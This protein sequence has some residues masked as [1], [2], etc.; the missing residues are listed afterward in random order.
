[1]IHAVRTFDDG[2][3]LLSYIFI[4][5]HHGQNYV[6]TDLHIEGVK[7][8]ANWR[9]VKKFAPWRNGEL[10]QRLPTYAYMV[11]YK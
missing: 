9:C 10:M 8:F 11:L 3:S 2:L 5:R 7:T 6:E 1:M 4:M